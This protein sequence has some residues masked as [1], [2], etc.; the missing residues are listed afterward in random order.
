MLSNTCFTQRFTNYT[1]IH[2]NTNSK[3]KLLNDLIKNIKYDFFKIKLPRV[4]SIKLLDN[5]PTR[6]ELT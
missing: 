3:F 4:M 6:R 1:E 5:K 2:F